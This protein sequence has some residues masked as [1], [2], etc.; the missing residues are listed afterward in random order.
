MARPTTLQFGLVTMYP[1]PV[2]LRCTASASRWSG[3]TSGISSGTSGSMRWLREFD[4]TAW[5]LFASAVSTSPATDESRPENRI[6]DS[7]FSSQALTTRPAAD[8]GRGVP[9][10]HVHASL[11]GLP[12]DQSDV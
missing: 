9:S 8:S 4:T 11:Y 2:R 10:R 6:L 1:P 12:A 7:N 5:P 3:L